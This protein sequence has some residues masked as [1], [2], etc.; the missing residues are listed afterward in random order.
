VDIFS[1]WMRAWNEGFFD[2]N[3]YVIIQKV[4][5]SHFTVVDFDPNRHH[6]KEGLM[7]IV[8]IYS[9]LILLERFIR[10]STNFD[11]QFFSRSDC[12][13]D[14]KIDMRRPLERS[15]VPS[16]YETKVFTGK[17]ARRSELKETVKI[18]NSPW[19]NLTLVVRLRGGS[20]PVL[21]HSSDQ[22]LPSRAD[23]E[24]KVGDIIQAQALEEALIQTGMVPAPQERIDM[25][26][27]E[28]TARKAR[29]HTKPQAKRAERRER[30]PEDDEVRPPH[31]RGSARM[32]I[33]VDPIPIHP[34]G[35]HNDQPERPRDPGERTCI[36][37]DGE[38]VEPLEIDTEGL[39]EL[40]Q[41][42]QSTGSF[43]VSKLPYLTR[44]QAKQVVRGVK[45]MIQEK[46]IP[47][48]EAHYPQSRTEWE[49]FDAAYAACMEAIRMQW[50]EQFPVNNRNPGRPGKKQQARIQMQEQVT[51]CENALRK[52]T[53]LENDVLMFGETMKTVRFSEGDQDRLRELV[54]HIR[55][56]WR[57]FLKCPS[58]ILP[59][60]STEITVDELLGH[61]ER[62]TENTVESFVDHVASTA[63]RLTRTIVHLR[64]HLG[65]PRDLVE[66]YDTGK[67][68]CL[69]RHIMREETQ[70]CHIE[71]EVIESYYRKM[72]AGGQRYTAA[73]PDSPWFV[74]KK[75]ELS[76]N[77]LIRHSLTDT[78]EIHRALKSR[79]D[80]SVAS[81]DQMTYR[82]L[83]LCG[84]PMIHFLQKVFAQCVKFACVPTEWVRSRL[85]PLYKKGDPD[86]PGNFRPLSI[87][88][89][90]YR[91]FTC[92]Y[93][94]G[95]QEII[96]SKNLLNNHQ[97][98]FIAGVNGCTEHSILVREVIVDA[99]RSGIPLW[100]CAVDFTNA[101]GSVQHAH[102]FSVLKQY[103]FDEQNIE[104]LK[105]ISTE[106]RE[107]IHTTAG[108]TNPIPYLSGVKQDC[109]LSPLLFNLCL[110]PLIQRLSNEFGEQG[111]PAGD[112]TIPVLAYADDV[113][114]LTQDP[115][116][117]QVMLNTMSEWCEFSSMSVSEAK[118]EV[119]QFQRMSESEMSQDPR[120]IR[121]RDTAL[122]RLTLGEG[123][124]YLGT[125]SNEESTE[126]PRSAR[127]RLTSMKIQT[128]RI[129]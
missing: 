33:V 32:Q 41:A 113:L 34:V 22:E 110:E 86:Q 9:F 7:L 24:Q 3:P 67:S 114:L 43:D 81:V 36:P 57:K 95:L 82:L 122:K 5:F 90:I 93:T 66:Q 73:E 11:T 116:I 50:A 64:T 18:E 62:D 15:K 13:T 53:D 119:F 87:T 75:M 45:P 69:H 21:Q 105:Y 107:Y 89:V 97:R 46:L 118:T 103:G 39:N 124:T 65:Y 59:T 120:P 77:E 14:T 84:K 23:I 72:W 60:W 51:E 109:P 98:G 28:R 12:Q 129:L 35:R 125:T 54:N 123:L 88:S 78:E 99:Q 63:G 76:D 52:L 10:I 47:F 117:L 70:S 111:Y 112:Q 85:S 31:P 71:P 68:Q 127:N 25:L 115:E 108:D 61:L 42:Y 27:R 20:E 1:I 56:K 37:S 26:A 55:D 49:K 126:N 102:L 83:K 104:I 101:Y 96:A 80:N 16:K 94:K 4:R 30:K 91:L 40:M 29:R 58:N 17:E 74:E 2:K 121:Y 79:A 106:S 38:E 100:L 48:L 8:L 6:S 128:N 92:L 44:A 19:G